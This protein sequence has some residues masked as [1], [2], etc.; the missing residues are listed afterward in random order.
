MHVL[1]RGVAVQI[2]LLDSFC[3]IIY[4]GEP[5]STTTAEQHMYLQ[6]RC[7]ASHNICATPM[8]EAHC[9]TVMRLVYKL[10]QFELTRLAG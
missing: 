4:Q 1:R 7:A 2:V 5:Q 10:T 6:H 8:V 9:N 3:D